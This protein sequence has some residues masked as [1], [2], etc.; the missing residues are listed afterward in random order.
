LAHG[1]YGLNRLI[2]IFFVQLLQGF[3]NLVG[4]VLYSPIKYLQGFGNLAGNRKNRNYWTLFRHEFHELA[5]IDLCK[6]VK[7]VAKKSD[8]KKN[9]PTLSLSRGIFILI[10]TSCGNRVTIVTVFPKTNPTTLVFGYL[11]VHC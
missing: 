6:F 9:A 8:Y 11:K 7:F 10:S 4:V 3:Q 5:R 1:F 2:Q